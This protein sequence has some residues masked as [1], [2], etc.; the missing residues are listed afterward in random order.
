MPTSTPRRVNRGT[1][2]GAYSSNR[3]L[4]LFYTLLA[5]LAV[6]PL[7]DAL[8]FDADLLELFLA[9]NLLAAV[10]PTATENR[11]GVLLATFVVAVLARYGASWLNQPVISTTGMML[12]T[13]IA[14]LAAASAVRFAARAAI[15]DSEHLYAALDAYL[16]AGVFLGVLYWTLESLFPGSLVVVDK[17]DAGGFSI[18]TAIYFSFVTMA[19]LGYGD[20]LPRSEIARGIAVVEAVAG[21]LFLAVMI[22]RLVSIY[23][24]ANASD[25]H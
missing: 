23:A 21:Q 11:G 10:I 7:L 20:I 12:W 2:A 25:D 3:Y 14:L 22:A 18:P 1:L 6:G 9:I 24:R 5:T 8:G 15:V 17:S 13:A 19:T 4:I 16:L